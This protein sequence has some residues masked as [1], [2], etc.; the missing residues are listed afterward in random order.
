MKTNAIL[1]K[2]KSMATTAGEAIYERTSLA[3]KV[4]ADKEWIDAEFNGDPDKAMEAVEADCFPELSKAIGLT[5][6]LTL[7]RTF[8]EKEKWQEYKYNLVR[9]WDAHEAVQEDNEGDKPK[10]E[11][12]AAKV[13][14]VEELQAKVKELEWVVKQD[15]EAIQAK[16]TEAERLRRDNDELRGENKALNRMIEQMRQERRQLA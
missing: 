1:A 3:A 6:L 5:H 2:L 12:R 7:L 14:D 16:E 15:R 8:P 4:L 13:A 10:R 9:L 11:R